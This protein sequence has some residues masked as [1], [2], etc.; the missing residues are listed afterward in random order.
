M[1]LVECLLDKPCPTGCKIGSSVQTWLLPV[2]SSAAS[3]LYLAELVDSRQSPSC[4]HFPH[5]SCVR[6]TSLDQHYPV[7]LVLPAHPPSVRVDSIP[8]GTIVADR[9]PTRLHQHRLPL[10][11]TSSLAYMP[12]PRPRRNGQGRISLACLSAAAFPVS[13]AGRLPH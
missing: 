5:R 11:R 10:L 2:V 1:L 13:M 9:V 8:H 4:C 3:Q 12:S 6:A 7:S